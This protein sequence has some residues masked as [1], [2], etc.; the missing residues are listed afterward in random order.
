MRD[1]VRTLS[2]VMKLDG[3]LRASQRA[4]F[5]TVESNYGI[6]PILRWLSSG[7]RF[8]RQPT[9]E[10][11]RLPVIKVPACLPTSRPLQRLLGHPRYGWRE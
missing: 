7:D 2:D 6:R 4:W 3:S 11:S 5:G 1:G 9:N 8:R 10:A